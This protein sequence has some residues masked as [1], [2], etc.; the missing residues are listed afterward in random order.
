MIWS[1][2]RA[3]S[4]LRARR[5]TS[6]SRSKYEVV[7]DPSQKT[8]G[9]SAAGSPLRYRS[10]SRPQ[11][12]STL[13][14]TGASP[15]SLPQESPSRKRGAFC[16]WLHL[17]LSALALQET[18]SRSPRRGHAHQVDERYRDLSSTE[19]KL[20]NSGGKI[21]VKGKEPQFPVLPPTVLG[22]TVTFR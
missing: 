21:F 16:F 19:N 12:A 3:I 22:V 7:R 13:G 18:V 1:S 15:E 11:D 17:H 5:I 9:I 8:R 2:S 10:G 14:P 4:Q 6:S 20:M